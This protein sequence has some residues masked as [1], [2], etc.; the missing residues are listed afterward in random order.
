[1][2]RTRALIAFAFL[3]LGT[4]SIGPGQTTEPP[5]N[6]ML[7]TMP[8]GKD[9][10]RYPGY[11]EPKY[12]ETEQRSLYLTMRDGVK[13]AID[14]VL[15]KPLAAGE[16]LP[17]IMH[18]TRYWRS[19]QGDKPGL[20]FPGHGYAEVFVDAR[21]TGASFG[22]WRAPFSQDEVKDY[23]EV[24]N[25]IIKQSWSNGKVGATGN[26]YEGNTA[27]WLT[28]SMNPAVRAVIPRH[29]EFDVF[30]ETPYPG[31]MFSDWMVK[32]WDEGNHQLDNNPGVTLVDEDTDQHLYREATRLR[33][34]N[35]EVY[36]AARQTTFRDDRAFGV[37][38]D[39][40][41]LHSYISQ[42]QKSRAAINSWGGWFD[43][44]TADAVIRS[45][46]TLSNYQRAVI[47]PWNHGGGQNASPYQNDQAAR[48][49]LGYELL[50]F[51]DHY[52]KDID[53]GIDPRK[54]LYYF[55][56]G[57]AKWKTTATWPLPQAKPT[58]WYLSEGNALSSSAPN[59][60]AGEDSYQINFEA[61][62]GEKNRWHTQVGGQVSYPNR[63]NE[64]KKL[65]AYTAAPLN[66]DTEITGYPVV[67][68]FV[69]STASDGAFFVYLEDVDEQGVVTYVTEGELRALHRKISAD[70]PPYKFAVPY[71]SFKKQDAMP[72]VPGQ[73]AELKFALQPISVL[74]KKGH[75]LRIAVAGADKDSFARI[76]ETG[77]PTIKLVRNKQNASWIELP[78]I[79]R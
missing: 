46:T 27:L 56:V 70:T 32:K 65:L 19:N 57:E 20:F 24:V 28:V 2:Q 6:L 48:V 49:M 33:A 5:V 30:S 34:Q 76:P 3:I 54:L 10:Q 42:I 35:L 8:A 77:A 17:T 37:S 22:V 62:T 11:V 36:A 23:G 78:V 25:W 51:F 45:F 41:S 61:T 26:S 72:L 31:G 40:V 79:P 63:A 68:L 16:K 43:A 71:H 75:R 50:R 67:D 64:D 18:M 44:S 13:I 58:R 9:P 38:L 60:S 1:M 53:T 59:A 29:F 55:T 73:I 47:G 7:S 39:E 15:P 12:K 74:I 69:T 14:V 52:L 66:A 21:G 4:W